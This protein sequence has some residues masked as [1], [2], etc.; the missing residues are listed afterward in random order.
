MSD[1]VHQPATPFRLGIIVLMIMLA[2]AILVWRAFDLHIF[3]KKFLQSQ[4]DARALR[5]ENVAAHRG[6]ITDRHGEPLAVSTPVDSIWVHPETFL[7]ARSQWPK[8]TKLLDLKVNTLAKLI[9]SRKDKEFVYL[10]RR[11]NPEL[12]EQVMALEIPGV[13]TQREYRRYYPLGEVASHVIGFTNVDDTGQEGLELAYDEWLKGKTGKQR[14]VKDRLGRIIKHVDLIKAANPGKDLI[15]SLDRRLQY[16]TYRE[17]KRAVFQ[18]KARSGS[19]IIMDAKTGEILSMVNQPSYNPNNRQNLKGSRYRNRAVT[20]TFEPGSATKPFTIAA[21]L[22]S[23]RYSTSS[24]ID[25]SPGFMHVGTNRI[26][27][28][29][30]YGRINLATIIQKS[31]N[32]GASKI[33]LSM[34][35]RKL[36]QVHNRLGFGMSSGSGFPGE[37]TGVL[38]HDSEWRKIDQATLSY[39]YGLSVTP[40]QLARAYAVLANQGRLTPVSFMKQEGDIRS[41]AVLKSSTVRTLNA[42]L[43]KVVAQDGTG[44]R[45]KISGYRVA[46][47]TGTIKKATAGGYQDDKYISVFAGMAPASKPRLVMVVVINEPRQGVYYGGEVSA[48]VFSKVMA[49]ALRLMGIAPDMKVDQSVHLAAVGVKQ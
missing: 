31:S 11:L 21:A 3:N 6:M 39:G 15:L 32:V 17:L 28:I 19:A 26:R 41:E 5:V 22:E 2:C 20:D 8:L 44:Q 9:Q 7:T 18:H 49:G 12:A 13:S 40:L 37:V 36:W 27:D 25:T 29:R 14:V 47:K 43:E 23:G 24:T 16:L 10:K 48:P 46:G 30:N 42:M 45:A 1:T 38:T 4:G 33:A 34:S 35:S